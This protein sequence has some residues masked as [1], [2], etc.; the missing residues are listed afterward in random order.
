MLDAKIRY[1]KL[2]YLTKWT[3]Y[4]I[5]DWRDAKDLNGPLGIDIFH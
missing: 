1:R 4:D 2:Q 3:S 5:P